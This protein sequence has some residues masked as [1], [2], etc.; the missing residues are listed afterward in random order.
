MIYGRLVAQA[1]SPAPLPKPTDNGPGNAH[2]AWR[3]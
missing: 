1:N 2:A 3:D